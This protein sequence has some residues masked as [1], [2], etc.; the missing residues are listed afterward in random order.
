MAAEERF[1]GATARD[2]VLL[3]AHEEG[4]PVVPYLVS[5]IGAVASPVVSGVLRDLTGSWAAG[6]YVVAGIMI[7]SFFLYQM[8]REAPAHHEDPI[9]A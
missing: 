4:R 8:V 6:V 2:E 3:E 7:V 5:E 1:E 9:P